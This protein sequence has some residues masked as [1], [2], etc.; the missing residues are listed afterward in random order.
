[1]NKKGLTEQQV[2][3]LRDKYGWNELPKR[4]KFSALGLFFEQFKNPLV[5]ILLAAVLIS[6]ILKEFRDLIL[7]LIV[8]FVNV[9]FGF[10]EEY[11]AHKTL[12]ALKKILKKRTIVIRDGRRKTVDIRELVPKDVV[13]VGAGDRVAADGILIEGVGILVD[14]SLL[15]GE[16]VGVRKKVE[17]DNKLFMGTTVLAGL[18]Y[19]EVK[20]TGVQTQMGKIGLDLSQMEFSQKTPLQLRF[21]RFTKRLS[22]FV[23]ILSLSL[24]ILIYFKNF[25][26]LE[27]LKLSV[28]LAVA[29]IPEALPIAVTVLMAIGMKRILRKRGLVKKLNSLETLGSTSVICTDK[30]GTLTKGVMRVVKFEFENQK[31]ALLTLNLTNDRRSSLEIATWDFVKKKLATDPDK[32]I[33]KNPRT[34]EDPFDSDKKY[35]LSVNEVKGKETAFIAGA[36]EVVMSFCRLNKKKK[37]DYKTLLSKW[38]SKGLKVIA[39]ANKN[40][41]NLKK[42]VNCEW[43]GMVALEDPVRRGV[44]KSIDE[45]VKAGIEVKIV[46]GDYSKTAFKVASE[47]GIDVKEENAMTGDELEKI[48][49]KDL[50]QRIKNISLFSRVTPH[51]KLKIIEALQNNDEIVAMT[52]DGVNDALALKR[53]N[54]GIAMDN[55]SDVSKEAS[56][57]ILLNGDF[58]TIMSACEEGRLIFANIKKLTGYVLSDSFVE[59]FIVVLSV[60]LGLPLPMTMLQILWIQFV[61]DVPLDIAL[62]FEPK[63]E[64]LMKK[65]PREIRK[66]KIIDRKIKALVLFTTFVSGI[67]TLFL[68]RYYLDKTQDLELARTIVYATVALIT[69]FVIFAFK[70]AGGAVLTLKDFYNN[71][72]LPIMVFLGLALLFLTVHLSFFNFVLETRPLNYY[73][74]LAVFSVSFSVLILLEI[75]K[76]LIGKV[77]TIKVFLE[78]G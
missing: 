36:P 23:V 29:T 63:D 68:F 28:I 27:T 6:L 78:E 40:K 44:K 64:T 16:S 2:V 71:R 13:V 14:E 15:T 3:D 11:G 76:Y 66:E 61:C 18:G 30:T 19:M 38:A 12:M 75:F 67:L 60:F 20:K 39:V 53:A 8:V 74:W 59:V 56:D 31:K 41:G 45:A 33:D 48:D 17:E 47:I 35:I 57:L 21:E 46:T 26:I 22:I 65:R 51:Q 32:V 54:I 34:F 25:E 52:G 70:K 1:M 55:A 49:V 72:Y 50:S 42:T 5:Y 62:G 43:L 4:E 58:T 69:F 7:I 10:F 73:Q 77:K 24:F 37:Q 9:L